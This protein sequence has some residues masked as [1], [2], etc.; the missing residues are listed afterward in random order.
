MSDSR[1]FTWLTIVSK[2]CPKSELPL[3]NPDWVARYCTLST[4]E[5]V[6]LW[7][8]MELLKE[9]NISGNK[10]RSL[11]ASLGQ[12]PNLSI[13]RVHSNALRK[14]PELTATP[15]LRVLDLGCNRLL[16]TSVKS[17]MESRLSLLDVSCNERLSVSVQVN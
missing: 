16:S 9:L 11:P 5:F 1:C 10:L 7:L 4:F 6:E 15:S 8:R 14:V 2:R 13:L 12:L 17:L 3:S